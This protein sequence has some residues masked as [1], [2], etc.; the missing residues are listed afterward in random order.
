MRWQRRRRVALGG[1]CAV[2]AMDVHVPPRAW[3]DLNS[4]LQK[5]QVYDRG[6]HVVPMAWLVSSS[7]ALT[8]HSSSSSATTSLG[9][10]IHEPA[11]V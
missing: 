6:G 8:S 4:L 11:V 2:T 9:F 10:H 1:A 5:V 3:A 7:K